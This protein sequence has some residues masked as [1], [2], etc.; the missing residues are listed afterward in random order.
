M[1]IQRNSKTETDK[2]RDRRRIRQ[3]Q[4]STETYSK[5]DRW[6]G[7]QR[8]TVSQAEGQQYRDRK[9]GPNRKSQV[10]KTETEIKRGRRKVRKIEEQ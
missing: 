4:L 1:D 6:I 3:K 9:R 8:Q 2:K 5:T 7:R 10:S